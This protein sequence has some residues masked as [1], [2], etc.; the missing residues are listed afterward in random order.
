MKIL[1]ISKFYPP[2]PGGIENF[3]HDLAA[4]QVKQ[5]HEVFVIAHQAGFGRKTQWQSLDGVKVCRIRTFGKLSYAPLAPELPIH[6]LVL[7]LRHKPDVIHGHL[8]NTSAF[9]LLLLKKTAPLV[10]HW[11]S[12]VIASSVDRK[13]ALLYRFYRPCEVW[14]LNKADC[15]ISTSKS[16]LSSSK[17]LGRYRNK[18]VVIPL[19]VNPNRLLY[20]NNISVS[21]NKSA[22]FT[23]LSVGRFSYYKGFEYL[24]QAA[25]KLP[26]VHFKIVGDGPYF[27]VI[28]NLV[29]KKNLEK[30]VELLGRVEEDR[31]RTL[32]A[33]CDVF[34]LPSIERTE[35]FGLV[36]LEAM[37]FS[38]PLITTDIEGSGMSEV[39]LNGVTGL[40]VPPADASELAD[41]IH[42]LYANPEIRKEMGARSRI[43]FDQNFH[44]QA[45]AGQVE[46]AYKNVKK[47]DAQSG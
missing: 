39:N 24:I 4:M 20:D 29:K 25:E 47:L 22:F 42:R 13:L 31:L 8:P 43:R 40:Q 3:V 12:D 21:E 36:L 11:H 27:S 19:G 35:A 37:S 28:E 38:K 23:V 33:A 34:C 1:H 41:A 9:W 14:L 45:I 7:L 15:L 30:R 46:Q 5:G 18:G 26:A 2:E 16:Y 32:F 17:V 6:A 10:L 44:I